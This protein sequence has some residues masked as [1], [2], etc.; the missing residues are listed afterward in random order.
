MKLLALVFL[1]ILAL[2]GKA[3]AFAEAG[4]YERLW[5]YY[6]YLLDTNGGTKKA[7]K[8]AVDCYKNL[9]KNQKA[10]ACN[11]NQF[12]KHI[13]TIDTNNP[14]TDFEVTKN[15]APDVDATAKKLTDMALTGLY[16]VNKIYKGITGSGA[17]GTSA[18]MNH[19]NNF[20]SGKLADAPQAYQDAIQKATTAVYRCRQEASWRT[21]RAQLEKQGFVVK[22]SSVPVFDGATETIEML[23]HEAT[24]EASEGKVKMDIWTAL[25]QKNVN[26]DAVHQ[27]NIDAAQKAAQQASYACL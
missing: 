13:T 5:Y 27:A 16:D 19:L 26:T 6:A 17:A 21:Q 4:A 2:T 11:F 22:T 25:E 14:R 8:I 15:L 7:D 3:A 12:I 9:P 20:V 18:L 24:E 23:D 1:I 10:N